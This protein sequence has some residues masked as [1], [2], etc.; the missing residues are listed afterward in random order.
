MRE[1]VRLCA[2]A[3]DDRGAAAWSHEADTCYVDIPS[4]VLAGDHFAEYL[5]PGRGVVDCTGFTDVD[6]AAIALN[7]ATDEQ[8]AVLWRNSRG[9]MRSGTRQPTHRR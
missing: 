3:G 9:N 2:M 7:V 8:A 1:V 5:H 4:N 6:F